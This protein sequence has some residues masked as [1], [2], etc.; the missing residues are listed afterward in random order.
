MIY[1]NHLK[2][3]VW[4]SHIDPSTNLNKIDPSQF[5]R[6]CQMP[7]ITLRQGTN[8]TSSASM[9]RWLLWTLELGLR[10]WVV[11]WLP[12]LKSYSGRALLSIST[13]LLHI[14]MI[15]QDCIS[16]Q[17]RCAMGV[18]KDAKHASWSIVEAKKA[19]LSSPRPCGWYIPVDPHFCESYCISYCE[20]GTVT[21]K[22]FVELCRFSA[23]CCV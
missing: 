9:Q 10:R 12:C 23:R 20:K 6:D 1:C 2:P 21:I 3:T 13:S 4:R 5:L 11:F 15:W 7:F 22:K 16:C 19:Y 14:S 18:Q 17:G 8:A